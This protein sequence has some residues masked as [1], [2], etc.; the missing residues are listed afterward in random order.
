MV[1]FA[2]LLAMIL[3]SSSRTTYKL[4]ATH[5]LA[6]QPR[7]GYALAAAEQRPVTL[8][9][10]DAPTLAQSDE[11]A[12]AATDAACRWPRR[13]AWSAK[14]ARHGFHPPARDPADG[15]GSD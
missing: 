5:A 13:P 11:H 12:S 2:S 3:V 15:S 9:P 7:G 1:I 10:R 8:A 6:P 14:W 4:S